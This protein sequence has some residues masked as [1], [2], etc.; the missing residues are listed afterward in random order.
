M[1]NKHSFHLN[2]IHQ[3]LFGSTWYD[4]RMND[5]QSDTSQS[6]NLNQ[7]SSV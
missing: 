2:I 1:I 5:G 6:G 3:V 4:W 7:L